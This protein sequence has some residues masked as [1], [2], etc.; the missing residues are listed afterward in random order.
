MGQGSEWVE[1]HD[2]S[3]LRLLGTV[4]E[5][6][7]PE[8]W[9][10]Y[11]D[12]VGKGKCPIVDT[13]WQTETGGHMMTPLPGAHALKPG[14]AQK[15]FFGVQPVV[16]D[17]QSGVEIDG[18]GVEGV[19]CIKDSWPGQMR[20]VWGDHERFEKPI[21]RITKAITSRVTDAAAMRMATTGSPVAS[22]T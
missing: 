4:G 11:N 7:N 13:W 15:P 1:K 10:W 6:I 21:S 9:N 5:P 8:A 22:T 3:D 18:N 12:I 17:P 20:T 14:S 2:L 16:L 19:L